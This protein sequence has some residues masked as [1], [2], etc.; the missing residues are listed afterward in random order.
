MREAF[1]TNRDG[2]LEAVSKKDLQLAL[3]LIFRKA[4]HANVRQIRYASIEKDLKD[5]MSKIVSMIT[6]LR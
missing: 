4:G 5:V 6:R 3:V 2:L 1:R